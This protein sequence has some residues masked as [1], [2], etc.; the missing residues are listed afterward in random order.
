MGW[1][2]RNLFFAIG[3][4]IALLLLGAAGF[5]DYR[6]WDHNAAAFEQLNEIYG[7]LQQLEE[8]KPS[9]GNF[10]I[11][12]IRTAKEQEQQIYDWIGQ[13]GWTNQT[14]GYFQPIETIP[15]SPDVDNEAFAS[16][17]HRSIDQMQHE[18]DVASV[19][20]PPDYG[21]SF[22]AER[23][24]VTFAPNTLNL[25][26]IQLGEV[27]TISEIFFAA[28]VNALDAIERVRI[29]D[30]DAAGSAPQA[31]YLNEMSVTNDLAVLTPYAVTFRCFSPELAVVLA[32]FANSPHGFIVKS[33]NVAPAGAVSQSSPP[34]MPQR[35]PVGVPPFMPGA[36]A[37]ADRGG[38]P[39]V[40]DEQLLRFR[41][42]VVIVKPLPEQ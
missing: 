29:S 9:P 19:Q 35:F 6:S 40:L 13:T 32:G 23:D 28:R 42:E 22:S 21:F 33:I 15:D 34:A 18:A 4:F 16:A 25:L 37:G 14:V 31:D 3:G 27:K 2:K 12:N 17:L 5:Y 11:D 24:R 38:L 39:T 30:D 7:T 10:R 36:S 20:L 8:Q 26:P 1:I 41:L